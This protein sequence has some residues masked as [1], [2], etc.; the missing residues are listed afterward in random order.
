MRAEKPWEEFSRQFCFAGNGH[1]NFCIAGTGKCA[2]E[3]C[4]LKIS[5][6]KAH[7][8]PAAPTARSAGYHGI[9]RL[10]VRNVC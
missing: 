1:G 8:Q 5:A 2:T 6:F 3:I 9:I 10:G 7:T 4:G